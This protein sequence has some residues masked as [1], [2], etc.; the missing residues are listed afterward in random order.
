MYFLYRILVVSL[1]IEKAHISY[2][3]E[4]T[5]EKKKEIGKLV[6]KTGLDNLKVLKD[7]LKRL[8][9]VESVQI[10]RNIL[11]RLRIIVTP[12]VA[13]ARIE[14]TEDK[15]IDKRGFIFDSDEENSLPVIELS[16]DI[17]PEELAQSIGVFEVI[18][19]L[20][21]EK[22]HIDRYGVRTKCSNFEVSWGKNEFVRKYEILKLILGDNISEFKG[23]LDLR[24]KNMAVLRR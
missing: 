15:V 24:F 21:A 20:N 4:V 6:K 11:T 9:W 1:P 13:V 10:N 14:D 3:G 8:S 19:K 22:A 18:E 23:K 12:R 17:F 16:D 7:S 2:S 5:E